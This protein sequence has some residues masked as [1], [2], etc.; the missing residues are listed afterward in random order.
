MELVKTLFLM[1]SLLISFESRAGLMIAEEDPYEVIERDRAK[2][3]GKFEPKT[4]DQSSI[5]HQEQIERIKNDELPPFCDTAKEFQITHQELIHN[6]LIDFPDHEVVRISY[7]VTKGCDGAAE[8]F[9]KLFE[10]FIKIRGR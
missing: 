6:E 2:D 3:Q 10:P 7:E 5:A 8:R 4:R 1:L 9:K